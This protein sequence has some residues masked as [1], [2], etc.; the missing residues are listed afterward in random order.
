MCILAAEYGVS[1]VALAKVCKRLGVPKPGIG[2][3]NRVQHGQTPRRPPLPL[4][5]RAGRCQR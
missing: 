2:Y 4:R 1:D 5:E 3:W